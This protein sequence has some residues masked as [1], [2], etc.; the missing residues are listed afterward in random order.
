MN[1]HVPCL[2]TCCVDVLYQSLWWLKCMS[3][4]SIKNHTQTKTEQHHTCTHRTTYDIVKF[5]FVIYLQGAWDIPSKTITKGSLGCMCVKPAYWL[6]FPAASLLVATLMEKPTRTPTTHT[7]H[8]YMHGATL[9]V[10]KF[11]QLGPTD[12]MAATLPKRAKSDVSRQ[13]NG[14]TDM[15]G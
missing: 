1:K 12:W 2:I 13:N 14:W 15:H 9:A 10:L 7:V 8:M 5:T 4:Y 11:Q 6:Q 3:L